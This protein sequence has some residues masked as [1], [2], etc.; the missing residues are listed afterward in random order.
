MALTMEQA[1]ELLPNGFNPSDSELDAVLADLYL[2][3]EMAVNQ[4]LS[5]KEAKDES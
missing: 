3:S 1:R 2:V 5:G 4:V